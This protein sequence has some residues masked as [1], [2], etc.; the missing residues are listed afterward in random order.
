MAYNKLYGPNLLTGK[1]KYLDSNEFICKNKFEQ[2]IKD[3]MQNQGDR[4][5]AQQSENLKK[6]DDPFAK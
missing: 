2:L 5:S 6:L 3:T 4:Y 1:T